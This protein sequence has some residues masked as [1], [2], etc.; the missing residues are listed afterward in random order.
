[1]RSPLRMSSPAKTPLP[2]SVLLRTLIFFICAHGT[3]L[4]IFL[5]NVRFLDT[6]GRRRELP[7]AVATRPGKPGDQCVE[8][9]VCERIDHEYRE[10]PGRKSG[11]KTERRIGERPH[12]P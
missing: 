2:W 3:C 8:D 12:D 7:A 10:P 11:C 9:R 5:K 1:M 4:P 6:P